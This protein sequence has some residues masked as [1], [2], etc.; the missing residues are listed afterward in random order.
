MAHVCRWHKDGWAVRL[1]P[2]LT[3]KARSAYVLMD[4]KDSENYDKVKTAIL[5]KYEIT[6]ETYR[7][8]FRSLKIEPGETPRELYVRLNELFSKWA[9]PEKSTVK[10]ISE[11]IILEQFLRMVNPE[12]EIWIKEHD[13][14]TA[15]DAARLAEVFMSARRESRNAPFGWE[16]QQTYISKSYGGEQG[17]GQPQ[18]RSFSNSRQF[19]SQGLSHKKPPPAKQEVRC[20]HCNGLG[21]TKQFCPNINHTKPAL[22]C[23]VP[24]PTRIDT[25]SQAG[26]TAPVLIDGQRKTA[27]LDTACYQTLVLSSLVPREKWSD[28]RRRIGCIHGDEHVYPT[29]E[30]YLTAGGQTFLLSVALA[31]TLPFPVVLG[32]DVPTLYDLV[33]RAEGES[34]SCGVEAKLTAGTDLSQLP[35]EVLLKPDTLPVK[36]CNVITRA[37]SAKGVLR[38]LPFF[39]EDWEAG[40]VKPPKSRAQKRREKM[41][42]APREQTE[43]PTKPSGMPDF[44]FPPDLGKL[45][46][47]DPTLRQWFERVTE[48]E[49]VK[50]G[51]A[52][53]LHDKRGP[54]VSTE[55]EDQG[56]GTPRTVQT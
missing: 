52:S 7:R 8:R 53:C 6:P 10:E 43:G 23:S 32:N 42:G 51:S 27:L 46:R 16:N 18:S 39:G 25:V 44:D 30:V 45:Q 49:G 38:E 36:P 55:G 14:R 26:R 17:S 4:I 28:D 9:R 48:V 50:Q 12:L 47:E 20:Y 2:L 33:Q 19:K 21:H 34:D 41:L 15:E 1:V 24:R 54:V 40:P 3:G 29:A 35:N 13:T 22:L 11:T 56:F 31:P 37:Q 5:E